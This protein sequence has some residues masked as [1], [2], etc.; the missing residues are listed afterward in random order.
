MKTFWCGDAPV[1][2]FVNKAMFQCADFGPK[3]IP[4]FIYYYN[5]W[6]TGVTPAPESIMS[7]I[8]Q[9]TPQP[10]NMAAMDYNTQPQALTVHVHPIFWHWRLYFQPPPQIIIIKL[11]HINC[12]AFLFIFLN[13][14]I[15]HSGH[16]PYTS[17]WTGCY[18]RH[19]ICTRAWTKMGFTL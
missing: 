14:L 19:W 6:R 9:K 18:Y 15:F 16:P 5:T 17:S 8:S 13:S 11:H 1:V 12:Y 2:F 4:G 7:S 10:T 3:C